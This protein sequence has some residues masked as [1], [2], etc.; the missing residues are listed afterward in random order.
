M[1]IGIVAVSFPFVWMIL[2]SVKSTADFYSFS[3]W[4][5]SLDFSGYQY[6]FEKTDFTRWYLNS[7]IVAIVVTISNI[8]FCSLIGYTLAKFRFTGAKLIFL[9][10]LSTMMIPTEMLIIPWYVFS[11]DFQWVD[12]YW[13]LIFPGLMEAFGIF[14]MRQFMLSVPEDILDAARIDGMGEFKI[15]LKIAMPQ[16]KP[17]ISA[18]AIITFLGNWNAYLW[19][20]IV[21]NTAAMRTLPVGIAMYGTSDAG[22]IQWNTIMAMSSLTVIP[23]IIVFLIFQ[24]QIVE[25]IALS[26]TKG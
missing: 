2:S 5:K 7:F 10:I 3:F 23:M 9:I 11:S 6:V 16:V 25:G 14:L 24:R 26:G 17:A 1:I 21:T 8:I 4:P 19:P 18:L 12:T 13:G 15:W 22:G 20:V